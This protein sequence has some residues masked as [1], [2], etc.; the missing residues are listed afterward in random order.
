MMVFWLMMAFWLI[1]VVN[2]AGPLSVAGGCEVGKL[3][4]TEMQEAG[5]ELGKGGRC[6]TFILY[7]PPNVTPMEA[8][9]IAS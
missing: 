2:G 1:M 7:L 9:V 5:A 8:L 6:Q 4:R 3:V